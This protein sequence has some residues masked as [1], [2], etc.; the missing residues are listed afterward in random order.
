ML[1]FDS[2]ITWRSLTRIGLGF[3]GEYSLLALIEDAPAALKVGTVMCA[4]AALFVLETE[5]WLQKKHR[6]LFTGMISVVTSIYLG[7]IGYALNHIRQEANVN[8]HLEELYRDGLTLQQQPFAAK[9][10]DQDARNWQANVARWASDT[11]IYLDR[12]IGIFAKAKFGNIFGHLIISYNALSNQ[13][14]NNLVNNQGSMLQNLDAI[15]VERE[16]AN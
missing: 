11:E 5:G 14:I 12:N 9:M 13:E 16:K 4:V 15:I 8:K 6:Y 10:T 3:A 1:A 2:P 7:F